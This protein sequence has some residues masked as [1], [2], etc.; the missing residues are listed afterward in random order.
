MS[1]HFW[2]LAKLQGPCMLAENHGNDQHGWLKA[3]M[4]ISCPKMLQ[5]LQG[6]GLRVCMGVCLFLAITRYEVLRM[7]VLLSCKSLEMTRALLTWCSH[8]V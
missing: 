3:V 1:G 5:V 6:Q 8:A 4:I 2:A 7:L